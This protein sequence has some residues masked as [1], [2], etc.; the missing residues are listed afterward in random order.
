MYMQLDICRR[1]IKILQYI[2]VCLVYYTN[3]L[4]GHTAQYDTFLSVKRKTTI[5]SSTLL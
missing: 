1:E 5:D 3:N 2:T 4:D